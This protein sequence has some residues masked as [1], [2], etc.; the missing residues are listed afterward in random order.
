MTTQKATTSE[1][2]VAPTPKGE[3]GQNTCFVISPIGKPGTERHT[4]FKEVLD[5][6]IKAAV[7]V[8]PHWELQSQRRFG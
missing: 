2:K 3:S 7:S 6:I 4:K 1:K 8:S 5:Y